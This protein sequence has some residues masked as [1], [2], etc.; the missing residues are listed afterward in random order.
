[1]RSTS[2]NAPD[3]TPTLHC[4]TR[5]LAES[6]TNLEVQHAQ[7]LNWLELIC[8]AQVIK[9]GYGSELGQ[10]VLE[11][12][13]FFERGRWPRLKTLHLLNI[14]GTV[15][16]PAH[17]ALFLDAHPT[18]EVLHMQIG[19]ALIVPNAGALPALK[20]LRC[21]KDQAAAILNAPSDEPRPLE[22]LRGPYLTGRGG[23]DALLRALDR[24]SKTIRRIELRGISGTKALKALAAAAPRLNWLDVAEGRPLDNTTSNIVSAAAWA[25]VLAL[26]PG[27]TTFHGACFFN[28]VAFVGGGVP[29]LADKHTAR[30]NDE[31]A[32]LLASKCPKLRRLDHWARGMNRV[33]V[34]TRE[35]EKVKWVVMRTREEGDG[36]ASIKL[37]RGKKERC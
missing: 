13:V 10:N 29:V 1:M 7:I 6:C 30:K 16:T 25:D 2:I 32:T 31:T 18:L 20:E 12:D 14:R 5:L 3:F 33:V 17:A 11:A 28:E 19:N 37:K 36:V 34:L 8:H 24:C 26:F 9:I 4:V 21:T 22:T 27:L 15:S 35:D 23:D